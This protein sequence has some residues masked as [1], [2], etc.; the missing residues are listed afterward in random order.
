[1]AEAKAWQ[2][3]C[4]SNLLTSTLKKD[5]TVLAFLAQF[6][7]IHEN[8]SIEPEDKFQSLHQATS[9]GSSARELVAS[10]PLLDQYKGRGHDEDITEA[11]IEKT[12]TLLL[13]QR[14][15]TLIQTLIVKVK[16]YDVPEVKI[17]LG[18]DILARLL[19]GKIVELDEGMFAVETKLGWTVMGRRATSINFNTGNT[20]SCLNSLDISDLCVRFKC[21]DVNV[22]KPGGGRSFRRIVNFPEKY[23]VK[24]L[25]VTN[26]AGRDPVS[27]RVV[28]K[29][30][31]GGIKHKYHWIDWIRDGPKEGPPILE[32]VIEVLSDGC[33]TADVALV[34]VGKKLKYILATENMKP[35]DILKT[36]RYIPRIP[37]RAN[38]GDAYPLGALQIGTKVHCIEKYEGTGGLYV[39]AA[40]TYGTILRHVGT[41]VIVQ[42][43]S[44]QEF[45][46]PQE[47]VATVGRLSNI[48]HGST[49]IGSAQKNRELGNRPRSGLWQ[50]K[51]GRHGRK[52]RPLPP[53]RV[54]GSPPPKPLSPISLTL[55]I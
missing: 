13:H 27:G 34:A 42:L 53:L 33:R 47:C 38:E 15:H 17:L 3:Q 11:G 30:I 54:L 45:S 26:L 20:I 31:G 35:G 46:F 36:S 51:T 37:V 28:A 41:N 21:R 48:L 50:R 9:E 8:G 44:K 49:P 39:H 23:T 32:E 16:G 24:P 43:P 2:F 19:T 18:S 5:Q 25:S 29:G 7:R 22:P 4:T 55:D 6:K 12:Q 40:G 1:M 52:I 14:S 10:Y